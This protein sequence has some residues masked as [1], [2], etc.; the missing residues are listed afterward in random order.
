M[1]IGTSSSRTSTMS[2]LRPIVRALQIFLII[3]Q[4]T[5][6]MAERVSVPFDYAWRF[7]MLAI[8][9]P[10]NPPA[11]HPAPHPPSPPRTHC[12]GF[13]DTGGATCSG[14]KSTSDGTN[15][16]CFAACCRDADCYFWQFSISA[17]ASSRCWI[18][19]CVDMPHGNIS[20]WTSGASPA[21]P[22]PPTPPTPPPTP[23]PSP[24]VCV[25]CGKTLNDSSW[26]MV[27]VPHDY[28]V[29]LPL[30]KLE[31]N[32]AGNF[33]RANAVYRKH[34]VVPETWQG[35]RISILF[36]GVYKV[37]TVFINGINVVTYGGTPGRGKPSG[38]AYTQFEVRLDNETAVTYGTNQ[39]NV[40]A[41]YVD[42]S[43]GTEHWY[44]GAGIYRSVHVIRTAMV[45][46][47]ASLL[48]YP[49]DVVVGANGIVGGGVTTPDSAYVHP[50]IPV[51]N[52]A[53]TSSSVMI[54]VHVF[55]ASDVS[56]GSVTTT[57]T[58]AAG[59]TSSVFLADITINAATVWSIQNPYLYRVLC[60]M[61]DAQSGLVLDSINSSVGLRTVAWDI[62]RGF[63]LNKQNVKLRGFCHHDDFTGVG[64]AVPDRV[65]MLR[66]MQTR[67]IG[68]NAWRTSHNNYRNGVYDIADVVG[69]VV[70]DEN[71][72]LRQEGLEPMAKMVSTHRN[73]PSVV[74]Y[75]LCNEGECEMG[76]NTSANPPGPGDHYIHNRTIYGLFRNQTKRLDPYRN[77]T[78]NMWAEWGPG[79]LTDFLDVQGISHP[80][81]EWIEAI[82]SLEVQ[83]PLIAS[84]CCSCESQRGENTG[85]VA[86]DG[87]PPPNITSAYHAAFNG[88]CLQSFVNFTDSLPYIAGSMIWT[89]ADYL[90]EP[91]PI[92][93]P[94]V[95][96]SFGA[97]D[98]AGF[99]KAGARWFQAWWL[100]SSS[101]LSITSRPPL[102]VG[103]MVH[104]VETNEAPRAPNSTQPSTASSDHSR[105]TRSSEN[106]SPVTFHV[107]TNA[108]NVDLYINND[109]IG[110]QLNNN[111]MGWL[112]WNT[113]YTVG[114]VTAVARDVGGQV[115]ATHTRLTAS[116]A[117]TI[118]LSID[119]PSPTTATGQ[120]V[121][122]DGHDVALVRATIVDQHGNSAPSSSH[123]ITFE[124]VSGPGRVWGV[125]NGDPF[126]K[127]PH[128]VS[129]RSTYN[130]L[131]R[132]IIKVTADASHT[133][134]VRTLVRQI[135]VETGLSSIHVV[136]PTS[137][138][139]PTSI[140]VRASADG[141]ATA[142]IT[143]EVSVN[144]HVDGV[145]A[146]AQSSLNQLISLD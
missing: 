144:E 27:D 105:S 123:N 58:V 66:A 53:N 109:L 97:I 9:P 35:D 89:L 54:T 113:T 74:V 117:T 80:N 102:P 108:H 116:A 110:N 134:Q 31:N 139:A 34:F 49:S 143:I 26:D 69:L 137:P 68:S 103:D 95:S 5:P 119:A 42:G 90:G 48:Y 21:P 129:W 44:A 23:P 63:F 12:P 93:W 47:D 111:W 22:L 101:P 55:D 15:V 25:D 92:G 1:A 79:T 126:C 136:D 51:V 83:K 7:K 50:I 72:D 11:P 100:Y 121:L 106:P 140:V 86:P 142:T 33:P 124:V 84:E 133:P 138:F 32:G 24:G 88:D 16:S 128:Q 45:H 57:T 19:Q 64:M 146:S 8:A 115:V 52:D 120:R 20:T 82:R 10:P 39:P 13:K 38:A 125:G 135:D 76:T 29:T 30:N 62:D 94:A 81:P 78:G 130:G 41:I 40:I 3:L 17:P 70:W 96:S 141:L 61:S 71:R 85:T 112:E 2:S 28:I 59:T 104:I 18:G 98:L 56:V 14:L 36:E 6:A 4:S 73:H 87:K 145:L 99:P 91:A 118:A 60:V 67:G 77:V 127:D 46:L 131:A 132:A 107:Y 75:S 43:Y 122:L 114:N 65:W 37:A